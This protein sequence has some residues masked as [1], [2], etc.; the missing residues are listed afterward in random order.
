M[1]EYRYLDYKSL[2]RKKITINIKDKR[3]F[4]FSAEI[5]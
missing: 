3:N 4:A 2:A 5:C 1:E